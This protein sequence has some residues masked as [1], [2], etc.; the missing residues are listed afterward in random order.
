[1]D[2]VHFHEKDI[3]INNKGNKMENLT[4]ALQAILT[5]MAVYK[6]KLN[7]TIRIAIRNY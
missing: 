3:S 6:L 7:V 1:M 5:I 4:E 2:F